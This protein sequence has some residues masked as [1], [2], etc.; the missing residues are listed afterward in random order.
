[1][2]EPRVRNESYVGALQIGTQKNELKLAR[3]RFLPQPAYPSLE[4]HASIPSQT[5]R[6]SVNASELEFLASW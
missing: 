6:L 5:A 1:M 3:M 2:Q 4:K